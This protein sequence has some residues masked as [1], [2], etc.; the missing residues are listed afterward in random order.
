M[1]YVDTGFAGY[2]NLKFRRI[3][4]TTIPTINIAENI[5]LGVGISYQ[6]LRNFNIGF[7]ELNFWTSFSDSHIQ[8]QFGWVA[9][10]AYEIKSLVISTRFYNL[11][12]LNPKS[13]HHV[14]KTKTLE[15]SVAYRFNVFNTKKEASSK[16]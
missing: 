7:D 14:D 15:I 12:A 3:A 13:Y 4:I 16:R 1:K 10:A 6:L 8:D 9:S 5:Q 2:P 11:K